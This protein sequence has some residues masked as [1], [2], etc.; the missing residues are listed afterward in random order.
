MCATIQIKPLEFF[1]HSTILLIWKFCL[2]LTFASSGRPRVK[3]SQYQTR[4]TCLMSSVSFDIETTRGKLMNRG[5][6]GGDSLY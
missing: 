4:Q 6:E 3:E 2:V 5:D 1:S